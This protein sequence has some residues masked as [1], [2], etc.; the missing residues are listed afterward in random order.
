M[1]FL[2]C[3]FLKVSLYFYVPIFLSLTM[4]IIYI[5]DRET[6]KTSLALELANPSS[7]NFVKVISPPY[8]ELKALLWDDVAGRTRATDG[9][10]A[11]YD[12]TLEIEVFLSTR[13]KTIYTDWV[14]TPGEI[15]R[16][17][18]QKNNPDKWAKFVE[19]AHSSQGVI[20]V[21]PP[22]REIIGQGMGSNP[23][24]FITQQQWV[25]RFDSWVSFFRYEC[26]NV[27]HIALCLNKV[28]LLQGIDLKQEAKKLAFH[29]HSSRMNWNQRHDYIFKRFFRP[30]RSHIAQLNKYT[31][32][33]TV[34][35]FITSI[36][37]R[38]LLE[39]PWIYLG[40]YLKS[41]I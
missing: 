3:F 21:V 15:W 40:I 1:L 26:P 8:N 7:N 17:S 12:R 24:E 36:Y 28:D 41:D 22:Y 16:G 31:S 20:L 30:L 2:S 35:C 39:L 23:D 25:R 34:R 37:N 11:T 27:K 9:R 32:S 14:D 38:E 10:E 19:T 13:R 33:L 29:P 18:W 4:G 5:G 6:G